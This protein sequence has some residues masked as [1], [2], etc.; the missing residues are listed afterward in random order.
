M[1]FYRNP[2]FAA[3]CTPP[4]TSG[5]LNERPTQT[6]ESTLRIHFSVR[7]TCRLSIEYGFQPQA[8]N[9]GESQWRSGSL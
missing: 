2:C 4:L 3:A 5:L 6:P 7:V 1:P 9:V 8:S